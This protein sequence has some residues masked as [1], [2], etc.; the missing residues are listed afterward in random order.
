MLRGV[1]QGRFQGTDAES[2]GSWLP[3]KRASMSVTLRRTSSGSKEAN[4]KSKKGP[5]EDEGGKRQWK[6]L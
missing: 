5:L 2:T 4:W 6:R 1:N 3:R